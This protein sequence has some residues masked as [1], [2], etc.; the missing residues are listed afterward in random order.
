MGRGEVS[1]DSTAREFDRFASSYSKYN[2][3]Q[4]AVA[5]EL[6]SLV[7]EESVSRVVDL[8]SGD[9]AI[10]QELT[11]AGVNFEHLF[12]LDSSPKM[13]LLHPKAE[14]I[15]KIQ[16]DFN[17]KE[18]GKIL[19][20][21]NP[22]TLISSS[23]LQWADSIDNVFE[24]ISQSSQNI[25]LAIF[26]SNTFATLHKEAKID[27]PIHSKESLLKSV[28]RYFI[29]DRVYTKEYK[30]HFAN[31]KEIFEYI[32]KSGVS[33]GKR[34]LT[35]KETKRLIQNYPVDYLEFEVLFVCA[36]SKSLFSKS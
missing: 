26:T 1:I 25:Y 4:R 20:E 14:N 17:S 24:I 2:T 8:G 32:K 23:A 11:S 13:L 27:S 28:M 15:T 18:L 30:L 5:K 19:E 9:G 31:K 10:Y 34:K 33:G 3:I 6:V 22:D 36:K 21:I 16:I 7:K 35:F 29:V 12:A